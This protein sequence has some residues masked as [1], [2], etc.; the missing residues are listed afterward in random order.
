MGQV[1][2]NRGISLS[3][4]ELVLQNLCNL[5]VFFYLRL[6]FDSIDTL[7]RLPLPLTAI[8]FC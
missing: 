6:P 1:M 2:I 3:A 8:L 5:T 7:F 4:T